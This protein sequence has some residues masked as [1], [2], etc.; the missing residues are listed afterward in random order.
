ML[1]ASKQGNLFVRDWIN[2]EIVSKM[3]SFK[4]SFNNGEKEILGS[5]DKQEGLD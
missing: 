2:N 5:F 4:D 1:K 3:K